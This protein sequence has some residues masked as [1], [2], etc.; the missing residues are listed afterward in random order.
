MSRAGRALALLGTDAASKNVL[1][2]LR[3]QDHEGDETASAQT[4]EASNAS[5]HPGKVVSA[6]V[7]VQGIAIAAST[8]VQRAHG[9]PLQTIDDLSQGNHECNILFVSKARLEAICG[10]MSTIK[11]AA[12]AIGCWK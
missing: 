1:S 6:E 3:A 2:Q 7:V 4:G 8:K 10:N 5:R 11:E 9:T 12:T